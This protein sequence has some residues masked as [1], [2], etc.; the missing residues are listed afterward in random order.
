MRLG[1]PVKSRL[2]HLVAIAAACSCMS[3]AGDEA[4]RVRD[5]WVPAAPPTTSVFAAYMSIDN[6]SDEDVN[7]DAF[8]SPRFA[9]VEMHRTV[10]ENGM[11]RM[12]QQPHLVVPAQG[13]LE[14]APQSLH[15]MLIKPS[16]PV[17]LGEDIP[18]SLTLENGQAT[19]FP[20]R[21]KKPAVQ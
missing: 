14:L 7:I 13:T 3:A 16:A 8:S 5:A 11:A 4:L 9:A 1:R 12:I 21:V 6:L 2:K 15:L 10:V 18:L 20:A 19:E 17:V